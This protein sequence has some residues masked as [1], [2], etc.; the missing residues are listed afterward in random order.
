MSD[1]DQTQPTPPRGSGEPV[2]KRES[3]AANGSSWLPEYVG[4][5]RV[6]SLLGEGGFGRVYR[7]IDPGLNREVAIKVPL[8]VGLTAENRERFLREAHAAANIHHPNVCPIYDVGTDGDLPF[9]VMRFVSGGTLAELLAAR[10]TP[11]PL[12]HAAAM[13][14]KLALGVA[15]AHDVGVIHRELKPQNALWDATRRQVLVTDFGLARVEGQ[16]ALTPDRQVFGTPAYM[17]PEQAVGQNDRVGPLSDVYALGVILYELLTARPPFQ[18]TVYEVLWKVA[19]ERPPSPSAARPGIDP[20][21]DSVCMR[22]MAHSP[23]DRYASARELA[24]ALAAY[25]ARGQSGDREVGIA[26]LAEPD[27]RSNASSPGYELDDLQETDAP[28]V[29]GR[30]VV[31]CPECEVRLEVSW[32]RTQVVNCPRCRRQFAPE[33]GREVARQQ[34]RQS[35]SEGHARSPEPDET[36]DGLHSPTVESCGPDWTAATCGVLVSWFGLLITVLSGF[37]TAILTLIARFRATTPQPDPRMSADVADGIPFAVQFAPVIGLVIAA[38]G[39]WWAARLPP[40]M[41]GAVAARISGLLPAAAAACVCYSLAVAPPATASSTLPRLGSAD[42]GIVAALMTGV[43]SEVVF[44]FYFLA[45]G[46]RLGPGYPRRAV[47]KLR[48]TLIYLL[49]ALG[50]TTTALDLLSQSDVA[51]RLGLVLSCLAGA[52]GCLAVGI[53]A[54]SAYRSLS[55]HLRSVAEM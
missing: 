7:G 8:R 14:R 41:G 26:E 45:V 15:A 52:A 27:G 28:P 6:V 5:Y 10:K 39:R 25:M 2:V 23:A 17:S 16:A 1:P 12:Y 29:V 47:K 42:V 37:L 33:I 36:A 31:V 19:Q 21:L 9:L 4:R 51:V 3:G 54:V 22:A 11:L 49:V 20:E 24:D 44:T 32:G 30:E 34:L 53:L 13:A 48:W 50:C 46:R 18:G 40:R 55:V 43:V 38:C 35:D